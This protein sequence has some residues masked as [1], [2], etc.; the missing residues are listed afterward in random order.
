M[1]THHTLV[2]TLCALAAPLAAQ[3]APEPSPKLSAFEP[4]VGTWTGKGTANHDEGQPAGEWTATV[5]FQPILDGFFFQEDTI[6]EIG[7]P[8]PLQMRTV[9]GWDSEKERYVSF[10]AGNTGE[11]YYTTVYFP[12]AKT[13]VVDRAGQEQGQPVVSRNTWK[14]GDKNLTYIAQRAVGTGKWH[15]MVEGTFERASNTNR[16]NF[17]EAS[18][19]ETPVDANLEK[20]S[21]RIAGTYEVTGTMKMMPDMPEMKITGTEA[22]RRMFGGH[23]IHSH[24]EG[25]TAGEEGKYLADGYI[26]WNPVEKCY[27]AVF[28]DNMGMVGES[29]MR[30]AGDDELIGTSAGTM[31]QTPVVCRTTM[32]LGENGIETVTATSIVGSGEPYDSFQATYKRQK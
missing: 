6:V 16:K 8:T 18:F 24:I 4:L 26:T 14:I 11:S 21:K 13:L 22:V 7:A 20:L 5:E 31:M 12:D 32:T 19:I 30:F 25:E 10:G 2:L 28:F 23:A 9:F 17:T 29:Q 1:R 3:E 27:D 15:T